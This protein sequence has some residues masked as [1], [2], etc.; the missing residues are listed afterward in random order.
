MNIRKVKEIIKFDVEKDIQNKWFVVLNVIMLISILL[1]TNW[2]HI[3]KFLD[4][5]NINLSSSDK[6]TIQVLDK[7]NL[8]Y[9]DIKEAFKDDKNVKVEKV[10]KNKYTKKNIPKDDLLLV[11]VKSD[12]AKILDLKMVSKESID[13]FIYDKLYEVL[14]DS[15]SK[16]FASKVGVTVEQLEVLNEDLKLEREMLGVDAENSDEKE[17]IKLVSTMLVYV[18]LIFVL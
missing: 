2:S 6:F 16:I 7:E 17:M 15:R 8:V 3:S 10:E 1:V 11:E 13:D 9:D 5:H 4:E 12:E 18:C 14:K